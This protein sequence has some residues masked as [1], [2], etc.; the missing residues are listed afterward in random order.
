MGGFNM[1]FPK[2]L[3]LMYSTSHEWVS[4][5]DGTARVGLT[6]YAQQELG[7]IV[8]VSLPEVGDDAAAGERIAD[9][10]SVKAV[11]EIVSPLSGRVREVNR[12]ASETPEAINADP[13]GTWLFEIGEISGRIELL[14][15]DDY[16]KFVEGL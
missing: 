7:D 12:T 2:D 5:H 13:Y 8:F 9:V 15:P 1:N 11:S 4:E 6:D 3:M 10:E 14:S 16:E